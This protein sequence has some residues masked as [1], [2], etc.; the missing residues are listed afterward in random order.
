MTMHDLIQ[1]HRGRIAL[2]SQF[3]R[4]AYLGSRNPES[5]VARRVRR[6][7]IATLD[8]MLDYETETLLVELQ[9]WD[10]TTEAERV[11]DEKADPQYWD[12]AD[13]FADDWTGTPL[14]DVDPVRPSE[15]NQAPGI[16]R[17]YRYEPGFPVHLSVET[18]ELG[19]LAA[20]IARIEHDLEITFTIE[21]VFE[22]ED[23]LLAFSLTDEERR[24]TLAQ[25]G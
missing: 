18:G 1:R 7:L 4:A 23:V 9:Y 24:R 25:P 17:Q 13:Q 21:R 12:H 22:R 8:A 6:R 5:A 14:L 15:Q 2:L 20:L 3:L 16:G 19:D 10:R 11:R